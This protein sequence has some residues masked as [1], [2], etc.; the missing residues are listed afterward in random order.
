M[1]PDELGV[2]AHATESQTGRQVKIEHEN[3]CELF[4]TLR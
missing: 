1:A 3:C 2:D 4:R